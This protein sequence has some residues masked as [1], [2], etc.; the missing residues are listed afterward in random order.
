MSTCLQ[1]LMMIENSPPSPLLA[2]PQA[3]LEGD[4]IDDDWSGSETGRGDGDNDAA[5]SVLS[6]QPGVC[7]G[8]R[9]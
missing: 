4:Q 2:T 1:V 7:P 5:S 8:K 3:D 9:L 6:S